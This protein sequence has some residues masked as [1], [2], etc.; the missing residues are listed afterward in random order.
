MKIICEM[1]S[2]LIGPYLRNEANNNNNNNNNN[3]IQIFPRLRASDVVNN[4]AEL[5]W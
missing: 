4:N 2:M 3:K 1:K 5:F